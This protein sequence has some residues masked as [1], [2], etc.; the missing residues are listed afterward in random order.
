MLGLDL[1]QR[2][3]VL[4]LHSLQPA[5][6]MK[7]AQFESNRFE[8]LV[9]SVER[10]HLQHYSVES[11]MCHLSLLLQRDPTM[12]IVEV[13]VVVAIELKELSCEQLI[14][15]TIQLLVLVLTSG[16]DLT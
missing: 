16:L 9:D 13:V 3:R 12:W 2:P 7:M 11:K 6:M 1:V 5:R 15:L 4:L 10:V 8:R 14:Q